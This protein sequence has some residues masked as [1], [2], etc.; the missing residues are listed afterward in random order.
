MN[1]WAL[2]VMADNYVWILHHGTQAVVV[3]PGVAEPVV[4]AL[5]AR[6]GT[7]GIAGICIGGGEAT[8]VALELGQA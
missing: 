3:D 6:G 2:P 4:A 8:A 7:K 5:Q 1:L